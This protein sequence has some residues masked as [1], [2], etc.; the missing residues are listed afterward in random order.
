MDVWANGDGINGDGVNVLISLLPAPAAC[1][2]VNVGEVGR[3]RNE[4]G[5]GGI[6]HECGELY[7]PVARASP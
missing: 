4:S 3:E 1:N 5:G 6:I 2:D 7:V